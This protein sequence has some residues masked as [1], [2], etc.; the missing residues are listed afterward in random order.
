MS[1]YGVSISRIILSTILH[2]SEWDEMTAGLEELAEI[3]VDFAYSLLD[4]DDF[5]ED[6]G[7]DFEIGRRLLTE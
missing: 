3:V 7:F 4:E 1:S 2:A 5:R 6:A